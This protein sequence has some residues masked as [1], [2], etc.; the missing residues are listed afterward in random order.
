[1]TTGLIYHDVA[2][3]ETA[4]ETGFPGP[5]ARRYKHTP[6]QFDDYARRGNAMFDFQELHE[7]VSQPGIEINLEGDRDGDQLGFGE[8]RAL[9]TGAAQTS[10][11][12]T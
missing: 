6:A 12:P 5:L 8:G 1:M 3:P 10:D 9:S 2:P 4:D 7:T 11:S